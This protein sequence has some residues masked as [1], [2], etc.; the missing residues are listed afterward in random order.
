[1]AIS[2][3][4]EITNVNLLS[5]RGNV[6]AVRTDSESALSP[7]VYNMQ[8]TPLETTQDRVQVLDT[9]KEWDESFVSKAAAVEVFIDNLEQLGKTNLETWELTR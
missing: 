7:R 3:N 5:K 1:M 8:N 6:M 4:L 2:W 9:I